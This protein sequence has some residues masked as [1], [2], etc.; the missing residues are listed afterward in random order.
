VLREEIK[1]INMGHQ[2]GYAPIHGLQL[3]Y[4]IHGAAHP[5]QPPLVLLHGGGDTIGTSFGH[6][7]P[8]TLLQK[9]RAG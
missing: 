8:S 4:E 5:A 7:L 1:E 3:Y 2:R 6:I 9:I